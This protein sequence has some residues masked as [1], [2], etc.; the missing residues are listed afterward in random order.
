MWPIAEHVSIGTLPSIACWG[1]PPPSASWYL[2]DQGNPE[3]IDMGKLAFADE[4]IDEIY[5]TE[6]DPEE[7]GDLEEEDDLEI[8]PAEMPRPIQPNEMPRP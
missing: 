3:R 4:L 6:T 5:A 7:D 2:W 8:D 1:N